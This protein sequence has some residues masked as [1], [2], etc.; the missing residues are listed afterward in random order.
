MTITQPSAGLLEHNCPYLK[1]IYVNYVSADE[2]IFFSRSQFKTSFKFPLFR[3][4]L[5]S[6]GRAS[7]RPSVRATELCIMSVRGGRR[8]PPLP[9]PIPHPS[10]RL[11]F[12]FHLPLITATPAPR[13]H[14][15]RGCESLPQISLQNPEVHPMVRLIDP[16]S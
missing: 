14:L 5:L 3:L 12:S 16:F 15:S 11:E 1:F 4:Q 8:G 10:G 13:K 2:K 7:R 6:L 9:P